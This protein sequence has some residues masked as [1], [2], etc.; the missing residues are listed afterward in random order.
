MAEGAKAE[1]AMR[2]PHSG[3]VDPTEWQAAMAELQHRQIDADTA[4]TGRFDDMIGKAPVALEDIERQG[5]GA[6]IDACDHRIRV[7]ETEDRQD[8]AKDLLMVDLHFRGNRLDQG[9][10]HVVALTRFTHDGS[11]P[12]GAGIGQQAAQPRR[13][14]GIDV[15][16]DYIK[17]GQAMSSWVGMDRHVT[18]KHGSA[19]AMPFQNQVFDGG[20]MLHV[21]MNITD[22]HQLFS[23]I[24]RVLRPGAA[25]GVFDAMR[26][27][28][29]ELAYPVPWANNTGSCALE[30]TE[31]YAAAMRSAGFELSSIENRSQYALDFFAR[32]KARRPA[33]TVPPPLGLHLLM[34]KTTA[35]KLQNLVANIVMG[36]VAPTEMIAHKKQS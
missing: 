15:T 1:F 31:Q 7:A 5:F 10:R 28:A 13:V 26:D 27:R 9:W 12:L 8:G 23:E 3:M 19:L 30:T 35:E 29:G 6:G 33:K 16:E 36:Y 21:G 20:Y 17:A 11:R 14:T 34:Q 32:M 22:K 4:G 18:L 24:Y 25:L 2:R